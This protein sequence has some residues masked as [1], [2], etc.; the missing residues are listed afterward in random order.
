ME[1]ACYQWKRDGVD[2]DDKN[3]ET[4]ILESVAMT[5]EGA[6]SVSVMN[7][8]GGATSATAVL[9]VRILPAIVVQ[10][11]DQTVETG[12]SVEFSVAAIGSEPLQYEWQK[13]GEFI[14]GANESRFLLDRVNEEDAGVFSVEVSNEHGRVVSS[15]AELTVLAP[16]SI[17]RNDLNGD[18]S[19]DIVFQDAE[20]FLAAWLMNGLNLGEAGFLTP[21]NVGD[22]NWKIAG[23]GDFNGDSQTDL[24]FQ[25]TNGRLAVWMMNGLELVTAALLNPSSF[26]AS[27]WRLAAV[28]DFDSDRKDDLVFQ[29]SEGAISIWFMD[30]TQRISA[31]LTSPTG[32]NDALWRVVAAGDFDGDNEEDLVFQHADGSVAIW[33]M[34]GTRLRNAVIPNQGGAGDPL[35]RVVG[36]GDFDQDGDNDL[37]F[38]H[39]G[40]G[41]VAVWGMDGASLKSAHFLTPAN[42]GGTWQVAPSLGE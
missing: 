34:A 30:G 42:P 5:D 40:D 1:R 18:G 2:L 23:S 7:E 26:G 8:F 6:Y 28:G 35:W 24:I 14:S 12:V 21:N 4:L 9:T 31:T 22:R 29:H 41:F 36:S 32:P 17:S 11:K 10:P 25:H 38:Q 37:L 20:G 16:L 19:P 13:N 27:G 39:D 33:L 15:I 3:S